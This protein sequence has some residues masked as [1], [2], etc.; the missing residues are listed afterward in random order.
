MRQA[1]KLTLAVSGL[2]ITMGSTL[3]APGSAAG[4]ETGPTPITIDSEQVRVLCE[5][6]V[7]R[8]SRRIERAAER[9]AG[10]ADLIGST[11]WLRERVADASAEG[12]DRLARRLRRRLDVRPE[13]AGRLEELRRRVAEFDREHCGYLGER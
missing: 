9:E 1:R 6:R 2:L 7:P 4:Q 10:D 11:A 3:V 13:L 5:Q 8:L 12:R